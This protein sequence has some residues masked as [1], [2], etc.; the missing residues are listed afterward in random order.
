MLVTKN[1]T[2]LD[3]WLEEHGGQSHYGGQMALLTD[4]TTVRYTMVQMLAA[5]R[6]KFCEHVWKNV[7]IFGP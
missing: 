5:A 2:L 3:K 4:L 6:Y 1:V 7:I